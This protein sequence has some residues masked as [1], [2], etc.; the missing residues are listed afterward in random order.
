MSKSEKSTTKG[1]TYS[2]YAAKETSSCVAAC[3]GN[4]LS[5]SWGM[6]CVKWN[7]Y[8]LLNR[9]GLGKEV[10]PELLCIH[11]VVNKWRWRTIIMAMYELTYE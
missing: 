6:V 1:E 2:G 7:R 10:V 8:R 11:V 4:E 9:I 3:F 5:H